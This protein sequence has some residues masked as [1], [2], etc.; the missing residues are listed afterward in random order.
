MSTTIIGTKFLLTKACP[1]YDSKAGMFAVI[2]KC[3]KNGGKDR[4][5]AVWRCLAMNLQWLMVLRR[6]LRRSQLMRVRWT[7]ALWL[8]T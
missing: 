3:D 8:R 4:M 1:T 2:V 6:A 7:P 5:E